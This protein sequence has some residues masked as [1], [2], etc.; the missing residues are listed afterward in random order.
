M[1]AEYD[2]KGGMPRR[3]QERQDP[4]KGHLS[5]HLPGSN[6]VL[7]GRVSRKPWKNIGQLTGR[8]GLRKTGL[9]SIRKADKTSQPSRCRVRTCVCKGLADKER[10][11]E[12]RSERLR[13]AG[14]SEPHAQDFL[15]LRR[16][17]PLRTE[18]VGH[19]NP[20]TSGRY[21]LGHP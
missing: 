6:A 17:F 13:R 5:Q 8:E 10:T 20:N 15:G 7:G 19:L 9:P 12:Q 21:V 3:E 1:C 18:G 4:K 16:Q 2:M 11:V 14:E